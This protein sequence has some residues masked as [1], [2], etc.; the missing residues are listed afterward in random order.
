MM[1]LRLLCQQSREFSNR[2]NES[3]HRE[4]RIKFV[5]VGCISDSDPGP[6]LGG[7]SLAGGGAVTSHGHES[8]SRVMVTS[9]GHESW[10]RVMV[11]SHGHE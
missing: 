11:T 3:D 7:R 9:H 4:N 8:W 6:A 1:A 5:N 10:S 2:Y